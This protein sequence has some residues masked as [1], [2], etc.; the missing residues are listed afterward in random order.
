MLDLLGQ[1]S[2]IVIG[3]RYVPGGGTQ[4]WGLQRQFL[5][6]GA[7]NFARLALGLQAHDCTAGFRAYRRQVIE[8]V[9]LGQIRSNGYS[10]LVEMLFQCQRRGFRVGEVPIIFEDRRYGQSKISQQEIVRAMRTVFR[11]ALGRLG[12]RR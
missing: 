3:S 12:G 10:F 4:N 11:L 8:T 7:N 5:S 1:G 2:D 6:A 9:P